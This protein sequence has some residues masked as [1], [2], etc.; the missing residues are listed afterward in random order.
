MWKSLEG[1]KNLVRIIVPNKN[2]ETFPDKLMEG[3]EKK[4]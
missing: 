2:S 3:M 4:I 1:S